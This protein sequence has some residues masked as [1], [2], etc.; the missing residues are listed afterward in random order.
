[1]TKKFLWTIKVVKRVTVA[2]DTSEEAMD[3]VYDDD[4]SDA[5]LTI[6]DCQPNVLP[7]EDR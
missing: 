6:E 2:A 7:D 3:Q 4:G 5:E 1:M